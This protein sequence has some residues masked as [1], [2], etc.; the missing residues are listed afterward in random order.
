VLAILLIAI[1]SSVVSSLY[2]VLF[3]V[4]ERMG[5][6]LLYSLLLTATNL[7][8]SVALIPLYGALG[9]AVGTVLSYVVGQAFYVWDQHRQLAVPALGT[10][11]LWATGLAL[12]LGQ[13]A[14][15]PGVAARVVWACVA[16]IA[17]VGVVRAFGCVDRR[18][19]ERLFVGRLTPVAAIINRTLIAR[20]Y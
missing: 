4:Q 18:L 15:G 17:L 10:W 1:P 16:T 19:V 5:R 13:V 6:I 7:A 12:G 8:V 9:A 14:A 3:S 2:T 20:T 11:T